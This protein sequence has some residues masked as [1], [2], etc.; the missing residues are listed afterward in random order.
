MKLNSILTLI[1]TS[2]I[3]LASC[4]SQKNLSSSR[5][6]LRLKDSLAFELC[7]MYGLDQGVR[8]SSGFKGKWNFIYSVDSLNFSKAINIIEKYGYPTSALVG[9]RNY[10]Q[11]CVSSSFTAIFLHNPARIV[12]EDKYF[13]MLLNEVNKGNLKR[14]L[15]ASMLD[16]YYWL[17]KGNNKQVLYGSEFGRPCIQTKAETNAARIKI[18]LKILEDEQFINCQ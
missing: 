15:F 16:K 14:E 11:E 2:V 9:E 4:E 3:F 5:E 6:D 8:L 10:S 1:V 17:K 18:G 12:N 7:Q 13:N